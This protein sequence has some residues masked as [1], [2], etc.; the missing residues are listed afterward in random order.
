MSSKPVAEL[1]EAQKSELLCTYAALALHDGEAEMS[2]DS[3][4]AMVK[5]SGASVEP[6]WPTMFAKILAKQDV[7]SML[8]LG[9]G[10]GGG[11]GAAAAGGDAGAAAG[12]DA[13]GAAAAAAAPEEEEE[14]MDF[15][16]YCSIY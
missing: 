3:I 14:E 2:A 11:G 8:Q 10:G 5:A 7:G 12:G 6:Y 4:A 15:V 16:S 9:G 13:G 1:E